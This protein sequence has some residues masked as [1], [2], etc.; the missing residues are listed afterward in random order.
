MIKLIAI[1]IDG[2][3]ITPDH[4][5]TRDN[6][7]AINR[8]KEKGVYVTLCT[9]RMVS[10]ALDIARKTNI[11]NSMVFMNGALIKNPFNDEIIKS[12]TIPREKSLKILKLLNEEGIIPN[13]YTE[14]I[15]NLASKVENYKKNFL[16]KNLDERY[17]LNEIKGY[18]DALEKI[19][20]YTNGVSKFIM[21]PKG[22]NL[23][24][25][26][27]GL[28][29]LNGL[30]ICSS[31]IENIEVTGKGATKGEALKSLAS[32]LNINKD[33]VLVIGD[34]ENDRSMF[35]EFENSVAMGNANENIKK[36]AKDITLSNLES[37]VARAIEKWVL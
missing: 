34:S 13:F 32:H 8:A 9:G 6:I 20:G 14:Y 24:K 7:L 10:S 2:T 25:I 3:L 18:E 15:L 21:F 23:D 17:I 1:D 12:V 5:I 28:A 19:T 22:K 11:N 26:R 4:E 30:E 29:S 36:I 33:E 37:G 27:E 16:S 31:S 35:L